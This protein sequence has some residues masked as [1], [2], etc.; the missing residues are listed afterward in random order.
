MA[1]TKA[2]ATAAS[3]FFIEAYGV[4]YAKSCSKWCAVKCLTKGHADM[5]AFHD[6][7]AQHGKHIRTTNPPSGDC[8]R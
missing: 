8:W 3:N 6:F 7:P 5:L 2:G 1:E 4:K